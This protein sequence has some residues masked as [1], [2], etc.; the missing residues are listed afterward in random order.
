MHLTLSSVKQP[1]KN[2]WLIEWLPP[3]QVS[4]IEMELLAK[5]EIKMPM[6]KL[7]L[8]KRYKR[9]LSIA[10]AASCLVRTPHTSIFLRYTIHT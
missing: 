6:T 10:L 4:A 1:Q 5:S 7:Q 9:L 3:W 8:I 2:W